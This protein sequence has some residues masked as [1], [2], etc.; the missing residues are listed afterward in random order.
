[1]FLEAQRKFEAQWAKQAEENKN[2]T[3]QLAQT[4]RQLAVVQQE[5]VREKEIDIKL[6]EHLRRQLDD[7]QTK[8]VKLIEEVKRSVRPKLTCFFK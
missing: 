4:Q 5:H 1:M 3:E 2:I 6:Q 8:G 7:E